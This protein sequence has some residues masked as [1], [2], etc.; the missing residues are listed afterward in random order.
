MLSF[1]FLV[2]L[3]V[4]LSACGFQVRGTMELPPAM[5][6]VFIDTSDRHSPFYRELTETIRAS[7]LT[8]TDSPSAADAVIKI[9]VD[10]TGRRPLSVSA[11]NVPR[12]YEIFYSVTYSVVLKSEEVLAAENFVLTRNYTYDETLV[13]GKAR[14]EDVLRQSL[15]ADQVRLLV[16][17]VGAI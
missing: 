2:L 9:H 3:S 16:Q 7:E 12:E 4:L 10:T 15:A 17:R 5:S 11:R 1:R 8:L 6:T 13:L 14:E